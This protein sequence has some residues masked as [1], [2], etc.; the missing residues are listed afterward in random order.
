MPLHCPAVLYCHF[1][2]SSPKITLCSEDSSIRHYEFL[3][4]LSRQQPEQYMPY[5][6]DNW[7]MLRNSCSET[8]GTVSESKVT[9]NEKRAKSEQICL[10]FSDF[11][12]SA[13]D[14]PIGHA[15]EHFCRQKEKQKQS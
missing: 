13:R 8:D 11:N 1:L 6:V 7:I 3:L 2:L 15:D 4:I 10:S 14:D 5:L 12:L 9:Q